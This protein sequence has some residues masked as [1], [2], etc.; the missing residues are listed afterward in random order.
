MKK[1]LKSIVIVA[2]GALERSILPS[3]QKADIVIGVDRGAYWLIAN[4][5]MPDV[6]IGDFDSVN[7]E[8]FSLIEKKSR[9]VF[10]YNAEKDETDLELAVNYV[11]GLKSKNVEI[12]GAL[13]TRFDHVW[14]GVHL[15]LRLE[16]HNICGQLVDKNNFIHIVRHTETVSPLAGY[17]YISLFPLGVRAVVSLKGF[18]YDVDHRPFIRGSTLGVSNEIV[19]KSAQ[20]IVHAGSVLVI[21]SRD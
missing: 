16:S 19:S 11:V 2:G 4:N 6:A 10:R 17:F 13:G 18:R 12:Y 15:L 21:R 3:V 20:I 14:A 7:A 9:Q 8:E 1:Q 5:I